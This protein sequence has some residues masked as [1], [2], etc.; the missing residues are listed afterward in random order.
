MPLS[1]I[2]CVY[3]F[4]GQL[5]S[6]TSPFLDFGQCKPVIG[7]ECIYFFIYNAMTEQIGMNVLVNPSWWVT[8][9]NFKMLI[10]KISC[11]LP[12]HWQSRTSEVKSHVASLE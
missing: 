10:L 7:S 3:D 9:F 1:F 6:Y 2:V 12:N 5:M 4:M 11:R 8:S